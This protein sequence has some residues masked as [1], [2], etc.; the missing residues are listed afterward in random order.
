MFPFNFSTAIKSAWTQSAST[1]LP[2]GLQFLN[3]ENAS[4]T[5]SIPVTIG[6]ATGSVPIWGA[7]IFNKN[8][9]TTA[10]YDSIRTVST[11]LIRL[12]FFALV[13]FLGSKIYHE[14][15]QTKQ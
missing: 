3:N 5:I 12:A 14:Y 10:A 7:A 11:W 4:G 9:S 2:T 6:N 15:N 8:A 1:T 13:F